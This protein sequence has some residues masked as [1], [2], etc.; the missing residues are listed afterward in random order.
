MSGFNSLL[1]HVVIITPVC[2][3][4][5]TSPKFPKPRNFLFAIAFLAAVAL[6]G[7]YHELSQRPDSFYTVL[8]VDRSVG[9]GTSQLKRAYRDASLKWH[10]DKNKA[11]EA[12]ARFQAINEAYEVLNDAEARKLYERYGTE[13]V[14]DKKYARKHSETDSI[15][16]MASF[17]V[18]WAV[19]TYLMTIGKSNQQART[20]SFIGLIVSIALEFQ[21]IF[22]GFDPLADFLR[23][24]PLHEKVFLLHAL[25]PPFMHACRLLGQFTF[26]DQQKRMQ[27]MMAAILV[28]NKEILTS[29]EQVIQSVERKKGGAGMGENGQDALRGDES[30]PL[31]AR[32]KRRQEAEIR[33]Q[34][35][36]QAATKTK[37]GIPTW[38]IWVGLYVLFNY[39]LK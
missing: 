2:Q 39:V 14:K 37:G 29:L 12:Q 18:M 21:M 22:S 25:Y 7:E 17:Y 1:L 38:A 34:Q 24:T 13:A 31:A 4:L 26:V 32:M 9:A 36:Q 8:N 3:Y 28:T 30:L 11:P 10:P 15:I 23:R 35:Q 16:A 20:W 5:L 6:A 33:I 27:D 19:L